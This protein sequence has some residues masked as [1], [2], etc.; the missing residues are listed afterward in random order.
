VFPPGGSRRPSGT[1][2]RP[3]NQAGWPLD[4]QVADAGDQGA[5]PGGHDHGGARESSVESR[6]GGRHAAASMTNDDL[7]QL[8]D[9]DFDGLMAFLRRGI[10]ETEGL[11]YKRDMSG[12]FAK[13]V[14]A[15]ANSVG[16]AIIFG[17]GEDKATKG[18]RVWEGFVV[19]DPRGAL[20][21]QLRDM[22]DAPVGVQST[23]IAAE[24]GRFF[25]VV[26]VEP[27]LNRVVL[28]RDR[29]PLVRHHD[30][31]VSP[32]RAAFEALLQR[33]RGTES[34]ASIGIAA[35]PLSTTTHARAALHEIYDRLDYLHV[36]GSREGVQRPLA[37]WPGLEKAT[38]GFPPG[39]L[40]LVSGAAGV[41]KSAFAINVALNV[42]IEQKGRALY[43][44]T[45]ESTVQV[46]TRA[47]SLRA[48]VSASR[49]VDG[50]L[51]ELEYARLAPAMNEIADSGLELLES[52]AG[53]S[54]VL[55]TLPAEER[56]DLLI[57]DGVEPDEAPRSRD[58]GHRQTLSA[59]IR[60]YRSV[61][62]DRRFRLIVIAEPVEN[63]PWARN[64]DSR[65]LVRQ[66]DVAI[67]LAPDSTR[68]EDDEWKVAEAVVQTGGGASRGMIRFAFHRRTGRMAEVSDGTTAAGN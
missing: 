60:E 42:S 63:A 5:R 32:N 48:G 23:I 52:E 43:V 40:M 41:G 10:P 46:V 61:A 26:V 11:D 56:L 57:I 51:Q 54:Q 7:R 2:R 15:M 6:I 21:N 62:V 37:T 8:L 9:T 4:V 20:A 13:T 58:V 50:D 25:L 68:L 49:F 65:A 14:A 19:A 35:Q 55:G 30:Q 39:T 29:G 1:W 18:P 28:H 34:R 17:V 67:Q 12:D 38:G 16:G 59:R 24:G 45:K 53:L 47:L 3:A 66:S 36:L 44:A 27:S 33:E 22:L 64:S 31:S